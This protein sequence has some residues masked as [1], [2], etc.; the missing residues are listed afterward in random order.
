MKKKHRILA[1]VVS[2]LIF[3]A[4][5]VTFA[6]IPASATSYEY[7]DEESQ[8]GTGSIQLV[9]H[10]PSSFVLDLP[11]Y[12]DSANTAIFYADSLNLEDGYQVEIYATCLDENGYVDLSL[13]GDT[14][15]FIITMSHCRGE[16]YFVE[17]DSLMATFRESDFDFANY[18]YAI[19]Y[20]SSV[21]PDGEWEAGEYTGILTYRIEC[22][23]I[24]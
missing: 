23:P 19:M 1:A 12:L 17:D 11:I 5:I 18:P 10:Q 21:N 22:N 16:T 2:V 8:Y 4:V 20:I 24:T 13:N 6:A 9:H 7:I 15:K 14:R 3:V